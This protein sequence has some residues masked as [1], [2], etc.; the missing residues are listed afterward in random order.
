MTDQDS[1]IERAKCDVRAA[2]IRLQAAHEKMDRGVT[3]AGAAYYA[4]VAEL[5]KEWQLAQ[6]ELEREKV[7]LLAAENIV[8]G[9]V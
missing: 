3:E 1:K 6:V 2:E 8:G 7:Y 9:S 5:K 4:K